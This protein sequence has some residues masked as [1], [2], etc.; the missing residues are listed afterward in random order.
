M[1]NLFPYVCVLLPALASLC[2]L[3]GVESWPR[4]LNS[5]FLNTAAEVE[6]TKELVMHS[7]YYGT[8][9]TALLGIKKDDHETTV[10]LAAAWFV[11]FMFLSRALNARLEELEDRERRSSHRKN[12]GMTRSVIRS[13]LAK[14]T[15]AEHPC[16][17]CKNST[18]AYTGD[19]KP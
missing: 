16:E 1:G 2:F 17:T 14:I 5:K 9:I 8:V 19:P 13:E 4:I 11:S 6:W 10:I 7:A 12:A 15:I 18:N 3:F